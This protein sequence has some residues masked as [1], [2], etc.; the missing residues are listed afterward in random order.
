MGVGDV[1]SG[2]IL[3]PFQ[4]FVFA[5]RYTPR[6]KA[7]QE[8]ERDSSHESTPNYS[9]CDDEMTPKREGVCGKHDDEEN[10][11]DEEISSKNLRFSHKTRAEILN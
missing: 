4:G 8:L 9:K 2:A 7:A 10:D 11:E 5:Q 3:V 6:T 1:V